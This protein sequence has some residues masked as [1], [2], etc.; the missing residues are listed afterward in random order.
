MIH[1][2]PPFRTDV[3]LETA[4]VVTVKVALVWPAGIVTDVG[5]VTPAVL[6]ARPTTVAVP[7]AA[8]IV[9]VPVPLL[10]P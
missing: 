4:D 6:D 9:T 5:T 10:P 8:P 2:H 1:T 7:C 3:A